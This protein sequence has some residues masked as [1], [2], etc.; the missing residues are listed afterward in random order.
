MQNA[1]NHRNNNTEKRKITSYNR[2]NNSEKSAEAIT[3]TI[4]RDNNAENLW[5]DWSPLGEDFFKQ[6]KRY[7]FINFKYF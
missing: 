4:G 2:I 3:W 1:E 6:I 7:S 5:Y